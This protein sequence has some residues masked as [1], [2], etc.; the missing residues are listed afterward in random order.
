MGTM[1][2]KNLSTYS[3]RF[4]LL[5]VADYWNGNISEEEIELK[6]KIKIKKKGHTF[7]IIDK[8]KTA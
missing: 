1:H 5:L 3:D 6:H 7:T 4:A 2:I 8:E